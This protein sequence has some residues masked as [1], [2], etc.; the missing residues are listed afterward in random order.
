[1]GSK[2]SGDLLDYVCAHTNIILGSRDLVIS[3]HEPELM[4]T[5]L[6]LKS[7]LESLQIMASRRRNPSA[8]QNHWLTSRSV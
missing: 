7:T 3:S 1:M 5:P 8:Y 4:G 6:R 2:Q